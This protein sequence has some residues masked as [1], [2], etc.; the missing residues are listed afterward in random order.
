MDIYYANYYY[1]V[2][3]L[4]YLITSIL[5]ILSLT[6]GIG[7]VSPLHI[8]L[9]YPVQNLPFDDIESR[10]PS[11]ADIF[12][13]SSFNVFYTDSQEFEENLLTLTTPFQY[14]P[15]SK[16]Q[17]CLMHCVEESVM[18]I[19]QQ[20]PIIRNLQFTNEDTRNPLKLEYH[21]NFFTFGNTWHMFIVI[22]F[23]CL[24]FSFVVALFTQVF[25]APSMSIFFLR[26]LIVGTL[27]SWQ[28]PAQHICTTVLIQLFPSIGQ[29]SPIKPNFL[30]S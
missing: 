25:H 4:S 9:C 14:S 23:L 20:V 18:L 17:L 19:F 12:F 10:R 16:W 21:I 30:H 24:A 22:S 29:C 3:L 5:F 1:I 7:A 6:G 26:V 15:A 11:T 28:C 13:I 8:F 2:Y 27:Y